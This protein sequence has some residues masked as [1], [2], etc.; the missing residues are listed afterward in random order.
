LADP[1]A[2]A[3]CD[4]GNDLGGH[5]NPAADQAGSVVSRIPWGWRGV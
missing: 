1:R 5:T 3:V 4:V 2:G